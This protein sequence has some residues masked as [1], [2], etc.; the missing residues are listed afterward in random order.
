MQQGRRSTVAF[1][2][3]YA[4]RHLQEYKREPPYADDDL[5]EITNA[6]DYSEEA[7]DKEFDK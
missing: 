2:H 5:S 3:Q 4:E 7:P 1:L 6:G